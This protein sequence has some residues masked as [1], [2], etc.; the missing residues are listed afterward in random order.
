MRVI[1][2]R[3]PAE[4]KRQ[5]AT[6]SGPEYFGLAHAVVTELIQ[7]LPG[8]DKCERYLRKVFLQHK[9]KDGIDFKS[10]PTPSVEVIRE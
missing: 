6:V 3:T 9:G 10:S 7:G 2:E 1:R 5:H 4:R 8:A